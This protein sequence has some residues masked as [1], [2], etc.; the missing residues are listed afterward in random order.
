M[1]KP[2]LETPK[3]YAVFPVW[4]QSYLQ[5]MAMWGKKNQASFVQLLIVPS[6]VQSVTAL[7]RKCTCN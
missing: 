2:F 7:Q 5:P 1:Q 3:E 6:T 4:Q